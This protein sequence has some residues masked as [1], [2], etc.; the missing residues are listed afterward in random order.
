LLQ[1]GALQEKQLGYVLQALGGMSTLIGV[2]VAILQMLRR[3][4]AAALAVVPRLNRQ[5]IRLIALE[6]GIVLSGMMS[7]G[8]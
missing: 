5:R 6:P 7:T 4:V 2:A 1:K 3:N 8:R